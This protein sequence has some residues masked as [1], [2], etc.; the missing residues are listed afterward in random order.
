MGLHGAKKPGWPPMA[1]LGHPSLPLHVLFCL[2]CPSISP[3]LANTFLIERPCSNM[4]FLETR[5]SVQRQ[6]T[7][8]TH[9]CLQ[10]SQVS[11][12]ITDLT[13]GLYALLARALLQAIMSLTFRRTNVPREPVARRVPDKQRFKREGGSPRINKWSCEQQEPSMVTKHSW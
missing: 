4:V 11:P 5:P 12:C 2:E 6:S 1:S 3:F 13:S 9:H 8:R 7:S 10:A